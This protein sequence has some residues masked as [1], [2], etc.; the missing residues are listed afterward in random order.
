[1]KANL[2]KSEFIIRIKNAKNKRYITEEGAGAIFDH[3]ENRF[4]GDFE[5][6]SAEQICDNWLEFRS[7]EALREYLAPDDGYYPECCLIHLE[8]GR[9]LVD[10]SR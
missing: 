5:L 4:D 8:S 6:L 2:T 3:L 7:V 1:M 10:N 9:V